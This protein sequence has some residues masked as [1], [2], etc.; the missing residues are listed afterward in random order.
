VFRTQAQAKGLRLDGQ[1]DPVVPPVLWGD[2]ARLR[3]VLLN[4]VSNAV[5]FTDKGEV[6][7]GVAVVQ[8]GAQSPESVLRVAVRDTGIGIAPEVQEALF[9]PFTQGDASTTRRYGGTGLGLAIAKGLVELMGGEIGVHSALGQGS[10][11]WLTLRL[12][13]RVD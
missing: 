11:F 6:A 3:Q 7:I 8:Q 2:P 10:T 5:K 13:R 9:A 4:L 1:V 12:A